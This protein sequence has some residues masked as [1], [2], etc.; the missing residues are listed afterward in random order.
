MIGFFYF[1]FEF[2]YLELAF[3]MFMGRYECMNVVGKMF[4]S[5]SMKVSKHEK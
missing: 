3:D 2:F 4:A 1:L 5:L